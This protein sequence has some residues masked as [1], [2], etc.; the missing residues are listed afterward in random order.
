MLT[1]F[2]ARDAAI[3][4]V[5]VVAWPLV[6]PYT[7]GTGALSDVTGVLLGL[8]LGVCAY[9]LHEW[10][11]L[12][13]ALVSGSAF[14]LGTSLKS[15]SLFT[16]ESRRNSPA[17]FLIMSFAGFAPTIF[18]L[19]AVYALLPSDLLATRVVRGVVVFLGVLGL[20]LE[21]PLVVYTLLTRKV[22]PLDGTQTSQPASE[23]A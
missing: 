8:L 12:V 21:V 13:G 7:G 6:S 4:A 19:W 14:Q 18:A 23:A 16:Y 10:G 17:Q 20:V 3:L 2:L 22:P 15:P 5:A 11:H 9:L 1:K